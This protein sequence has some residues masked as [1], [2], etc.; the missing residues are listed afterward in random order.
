MKN[1]LW[2]YGCD[3]F[4]SAKKFRSSHSGKFPKIILDSNIS[5]RHSFF[6]KSVNSLPG[7][8]ITIF[9]EIEKAV[10]N[11]A[12]L[13]NSKFELLPDDNEINELKKTLLIEYK[14]LFNDKLIN[15]HLNYLNSIPSLK[16]KT[17][18]EKVNALIKHYQ[19]HNESSS[20]NFHLVLCL[21]NI[22]INCD[23]QGYFKKLLHYPQEQYSL[24][25]TKNILFDLFLIEE[26]NR[27][28]DE[29]DDIFFCT[30]DF[31]AA[32][33]AN[34][35]TKLTLCITIHNLHKEP[36]K[37][38]LYG[39]EKDVYANLSN[40]SEFTGIIKKIREFIYKRWDGEYKRKYTF[41]IKPIAEAI[42]RSFN[43]N[44]L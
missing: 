23:S 38:S 39:I 37:E 40:E 41:Q 11:N 2:V 34:Y 4:G 33:Y 31:G 26:V 29:G 8:K 18:L 5:G 27:F 22:N 24:K 19:E 14:K 9:A 42:A 1:D 35:I 36:A 17:K 44:Y 12:N 43:I 15:K 32:Y 10:N 20:I 16:N 7:D 3:F 28:I 6:S 25:L 13:E 30:N 21:I